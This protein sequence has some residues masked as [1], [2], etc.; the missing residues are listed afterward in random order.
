[1]LPVL[2]MRTLGS[3]NMKWFLCS[4]GVNDIQP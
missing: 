3:Q 1:M 4:T 2:D